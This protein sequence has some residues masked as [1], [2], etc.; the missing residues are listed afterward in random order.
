MLAHLSTFSSEP[1]RSR[2]GGT[3]A[4]WKQVAWSLAGFAFVIASFDLCVKLSCAIPK[5]EQ[6]PQTALQRYFSYG[7]SIERKL[8]RTVGSVGQ[9]PADI[10]RAGWIPTEVRKPPSDWDAGGMKIV[11]YGMSF[12]NRI[13]AQL[14]E[15][16]PDLAI[17]TRAGPAAPLSHSYA[18]F[19]AD[20]Y[21]SEAKYVVVGILSSSIP[22]MQ[23]MSGLGFTPENPAPYTYPKFVANDDKLTRVDPI[24]NSRDE[25]IE[26]FRSNAPEWNDHLH[27]LQQRDPYWSDIL[28]YK[29]IVDQSATLSLLRRAWGKHHIESVT[30]RVYSAEHGYN[31]RNE[32]MAAIP[33]IL[34]DIHR[35][36]A[37]DRQHLIVILLHARG[38]PNN[39]DHWLRPELEA[40]GITVVSTSDFFDSTDGLNFESDGHY[41]P[42]LD[43]EL[44]RRVRDIISP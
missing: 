14:D 9:H 44:A 8:I 26:A 20:S 11:F 34:D 25:F 17:L 27:L 31:T 23:G 12:T 39:L 19:N 10:I 33:L 2:I 4:W 35:R 22:Y 43:A 30:A 41:L 5:G 18:L 42:S 3:R 6:Y 36:C 24:I 28:Y 15:M 29:S 37:S 1:G 13:A 16:R 21:R 40:S 38:E 7:E 32:T